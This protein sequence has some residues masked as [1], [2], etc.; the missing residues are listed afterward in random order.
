MKPC[1][2]RVDSHEATARSAHASEKLGA[3][4]CEGGTPSGMSKPTMY[5]EMAAHAPGHRLQAQALL[6]CARGIAERL[7]AQAH[8]LHEELTPI[9][10][11]L[12][13]LVEAMPSE[14]GEY[15]QARFILECIEKMLSGA[16]EAQQR[17]HQ[18]VADLNKALA[19]EQA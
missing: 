10:N 11:E 19:N 13:A 9:R 18:I 2:E 5:A 4:W 3:N 12:G 15:Q 6:P 8:T 1:E 16:E 14:L 17:A 7:S